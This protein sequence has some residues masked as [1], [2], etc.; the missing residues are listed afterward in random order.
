L[1]KCQKEGAEFR[2]QRLERRVNATKNSICVLFLAS[3]ELVALSVYFRV[4]SV[5]R[6][7]VRYG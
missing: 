1:E 6:G 2:G 7:E 5:F 3:V 4:F